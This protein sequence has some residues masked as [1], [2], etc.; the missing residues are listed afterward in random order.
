MSTARR[1]ARELFVL[2]AG[3]FAG[4]GVGLLG[5][6]VV[7]RALG[8]EGR[9]VHA[10]LLTLAAIGVQLALLAPPHAVR[11]LAGQAGGRLPATL[12][13]LCG[14][15]TLLTLPLAGYAFSDPIDPAARPLVVIAW[16]AVPAT[17]SALALFAL[18]Q[19]QGPAA[20]LLV[21]QIAPRLFQLL[22]V[23]ALAAAGRLD[24]EAAIWL[25]LA[26]ALATLALTIAF[27][28]PLPRD[29][30][31][32]PALA[33]A[34][35]RH[36][37][38][39][40]ISALALFCTPR[41]GL[42]ALG[43]TAPVEAL[44]QYGL[45]LALQETAMAV[46]AALGGILITH[47]SLHGAPTSGNRARA[48]GLILAPAMAA[49]LV[50]ALLAPAVVPW[51]FGASFAPAAGLFQGLL[52]TVVL[53]TLFQLCQPLLIA[54]GRPVPI[55]LPSLAAFTVATATALLAIP[56]HGAWGAVGSNVAGFATLAA[57]AAWLGPGRAPER[58]T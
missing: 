41:I 10:W 9:G 39:G 45:A 26:T 27:L 51:L 34:L 25:H 52:V 23:I 37:G 1:L 48:A 43:W 7:T 40:W 12:A 21:V 54:R 42:V 2:T 3:H 35:A 57:L 58:A 53:A 17:A 50:A 29:L 20:P 8:P 36:L 16:L 56:R 55:A 28:R 47:V 30:R 31:P 49:C 5:T 14:L 18:V 32:D 19:M 11:A 6:V 4:L 13:A 24:L 33:G 44:G 38:L 15:G 46:P 22:L